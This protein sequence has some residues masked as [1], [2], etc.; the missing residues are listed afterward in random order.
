M[1]TIF[2][3][4]FFEILPFSFSVLASFYNLIQLV[5]QLIDIMAILIVLI[6][7]IQSI[8]PFL[9]YIV[10]ATFRP[11]SQISKEDNGN[12]TDTSTDTKSKRLLIND[13]YNSSKKS[14]VNG[15]LLVLELE[16]A[17]AILKMGVFTSS[18]VGLNSLLLQSPSSIQALSGNFLF[19]VVILSLRI[20]IN[21]TLRR[22]S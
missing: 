21:Q 10:R 1:Q 14:F 20:A 16:S 4:T 22:F 6:S 5:I 18:S 12:N 9:S 17:N 2:P 19:F 13:R 15:L 8:K 7:I 11:S 3:S